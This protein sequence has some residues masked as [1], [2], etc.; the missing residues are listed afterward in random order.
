MGVFECGA[1]VP[2]ILSV[3]LPSLA[4]VQACQISVLMQ[5]PRAIAPG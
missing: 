1:D 5:R 3:S 2:P 4:V